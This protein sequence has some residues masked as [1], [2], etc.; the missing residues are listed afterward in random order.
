MD[1]SDELS[2]LLRHRTFQLYH[3]IHW[4]GHISIAWTV[5]NGHQFQWIFT[6]PS[7][8]SMHYVATWI[9]RLKKRTVV[10]Q[11]RDILDTSWYTW[12]DTPCTMVWWPQTS[13]S[14]L[15][16]VEASRFNYSQVLQPTVEAARGCTWVGAIS[17]YPYTQTSYLSFFL[18]RDFLITFD[19]T[20]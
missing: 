10:G 11:P 8:I 3:L 7:P 6:R 14:V 13:T 5:S 20:P 18:H 16:R 4:S 2:Q 1:C 19:K 12:L 15:F 9:K 17:K